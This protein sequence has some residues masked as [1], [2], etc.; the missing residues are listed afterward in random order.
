MKTQ[1]LRKENSVFAKAAE[2]WQLLKL[3]V[4]RRDLLERKLKNAQTSF[5]YQKLLSYVFQQ[6]AGV[7]HLLI[8]PAGSSVREASSCSRPVEGTDTTQTV[9]HFTTTAQEQDKETQQRD[10]LSYSAQAVLGNRKA[11]SVLIWSAI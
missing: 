9:P 10:C 7:F 3:E 8:V 4:P 5:I 6:I 2:R 11:A 1:K